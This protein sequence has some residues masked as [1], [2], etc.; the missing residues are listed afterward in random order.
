MTVDAGPPPS[1]PAAIAQEDA[2]QRR[3]LMRQRGAFD[4]V[5]VV[6]ED[7][8]VLLRFGSPDGADQSAVDPRAPDRVIFEYVRIAAAAP[9]LR[10]DGRPFRS[11]LMLGL[12]GGAWPRLIMGHHPRAVIDAVDVDPL[13]IE[14]AKR[15][16]FVEEGPRLR[17]HADDAARYVE[18]P[19]VRERRYD[20][21]FVDAFSGEAMPPSLSTPTFFQALKRILTDDGVLAVNVAL[22]S[23]SDAQAI[24]TRISDAFPGCS[25]AR[26]RQEEN[27]L[28]FAGKRP[29][30]ATAVRSALIKAGIDVNLD[31]VR[32]VSDV[33]ACPT[34][35]PTST[36]GQKLFE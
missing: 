23:D 26:A 30:G 3:V 2:P 34:P 17:L 10:P 8:L 14:A 7:G 11:A 28:V 22:V 36:A 29:I 32:D 21:I 6:E 33:V 15:F 12:G 35:A 18:R 4:D 1:P 27:Q 20:V 19:E 16:F 13:V 31:I 9:A 25:W 24:I 5:V